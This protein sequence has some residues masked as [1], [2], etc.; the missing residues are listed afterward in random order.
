MS[1]RFQESA[2]FSPGDFATGCVL[3]LVVAMAASL[4]FDVQ[5]AEAE[6]SAQVTH[7]VL[8]QD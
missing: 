3:A 2:D 6:I 1:K 7:T 4:S 5:P 8:A